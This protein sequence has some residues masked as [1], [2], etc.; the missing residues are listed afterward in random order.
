MKGT[1]RAWVGCRFVVAG[2][3]VST[4]SGCGAFRGA[5]VPNA[6]LPDEPVTLLYGLNDRGA[7]QWLK[8][9]EEGHIRAFVPL[10]QAQAAVHRAAAAGAVAQYAAEELAQAKARLVDAEKIWHSIASAPLD[11]RERL[12]IA[13]NAA[14]QAKRYAQIATGI[15]A[16][17]TGLQQLLDVQ[18]ALQNEQAVQRANATADADWLGKELIPGKW[19]A[20]HF[21][22][23]TAELTRESAQTIHNLVAFLGAHARYGLRLAGHTDDSA[24]DAARLHA[25]LEQHQELAERKTNKMARVAAYNQALSLRRA[26]ALR[27][28]LLDAGIDGGRLSVIGRGASEPIADNATAMGRSKNRRVVAT[29]VLAQEPA[30]TPAAE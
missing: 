16:R 13:A 8:R 22:L 5:P 9:D 23:G 1:V 20:V 4:L 2:L 28:A 12:I 3:L 27:Q 21:A 29:V 6:F 15:A 24:P 19:G 10:Q 18:A 14:H 25:F 17:E 11:Q 7:S 26:Q 30:D